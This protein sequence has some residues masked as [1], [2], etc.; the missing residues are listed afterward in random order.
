LPAAYLTRFG[1]DG[2]VT[3]RWRTRPKLITTNVINVAVESGFHESTE[4]PPL[5]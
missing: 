5:G 1:K 2:Q 4:E 3:M